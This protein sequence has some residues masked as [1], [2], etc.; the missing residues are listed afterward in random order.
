MVVDVHV[1]KLEAKLA[2]ANEIGAS[3][4]T[5]RVY[6][7]K[8]CI[9]SINLKL[10]ALL[11]AAAKMFPRKL[12]PNVLLPV[13]KSFAANYCCPYGHRTRNLSTPIFIFVV[14]IQLQKENKSIERTN[15]FNKKRYVC[16]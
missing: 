5:E 4:G 8:S 11:A 1:A 12:L 7:L 6:D 15:S 14:T 10:P 13:Y 2:Q 3:A 16:R 9:I